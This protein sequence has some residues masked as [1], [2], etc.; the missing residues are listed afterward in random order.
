VKERQSLGQDLLK[1]EKNESNPYVATVTGLVGYQWETE[2]VMS[3][4]A[5][6]KL[7]KPRDLLLSERETGSS[8]MGVG[9][10]LGP[11]DKQKSSITA[12]PPAAS[13]RGRQ[14]KQKILAAAAELFL[15]NGY[16]YTTMDA[17]VEKSGGSKATLY[18][19][20]PNK[21]ELFRAVVDRVVSI[22][23]PAELGCYENIEQD[24]THFAAQRLRV[25][26]S[27]EHM[28]LLRLI[29]AERD[30][31][32]DIARLYY[33]EGP[34]RSYQALS[35]Y[36]REIDERRLLSIPDVEEAAEFFAGMLMHQWYLEQLYLSFEAPAE[37]DILGRARDVVARFLRSYGAKRSLAE[38]GEELR[39]D[40]R[41]P[42]C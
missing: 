39:K 21:G 37:A 35:A 34:Q 19:L 40:A 2:H 24:L 28:A 36:F 11:K 18:S 16:G 14:R 7:E 20:F 25:V 22:R 5:L 10:V 42:A 6:G 33:Q 31:F 12:A 32:P 41:E 8:T 1:K 3:W 23:D 9:G 13:K 26:F 29:I 38:T 30:R 15:K 27:T 17:V 4:L